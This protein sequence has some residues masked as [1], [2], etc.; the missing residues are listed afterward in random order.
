MK[1]LLSSLILGLAVLTGCQAP[2]N[3]GTVTGKRFSEEHTEVWY[4]PN[5][6]YMY[7]GG[8]MKMIYLGQKENYSHHPDEW[9]ITITDGTRTSEIEVHPSDYESYTEGETYP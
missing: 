7:V 2:L 8:Q 3:T 6:M 1:R 5:Y 4:S 9:F